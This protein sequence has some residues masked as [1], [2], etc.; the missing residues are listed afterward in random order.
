LH[1]GELSIWT[2]IIDPVFLNTEQNVGENIPFS[3]DQNYPN[4]FNKTT[5]FSFKLKKTSTVTLKIVD[6]FGREIA[7]L[8]DNE[9]MKPGMY[10]EHFN[11]STHNLPSGIYYFSLTDENQNQVRKMV[12]ER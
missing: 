6:V 4:P 3:L 10:V 7:R 12:V 1:D 2:A 5:H 11:A 8:I 9:K